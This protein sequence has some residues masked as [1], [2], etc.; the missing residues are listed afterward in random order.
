MNSFLIALMFASQYH[1][2]NLN[3][4]FARFVSEVILTWT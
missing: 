3:I 2:L 1:L 4:S